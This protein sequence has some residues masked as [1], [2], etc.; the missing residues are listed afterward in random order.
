ME[1][2][3]MNFIRKLKCLLRLHD[4]EYKMIETHYTFFDLGREIGDYRK[5]K[6]YSVCKHFGHENKKL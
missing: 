4:Y 1:Y 6:W 2:A 5:Q 3:R